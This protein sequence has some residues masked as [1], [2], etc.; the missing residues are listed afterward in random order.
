[1]KLF[2]APVV[3]A[4]LATSAAAFDRQ[5][6]DAL[7]ICH[8]YL[9]EVPDFAALPNAAISVFPGIMD[10]ET[11]TVFWNILWDDPDVRA[12]GNCTVISGELQGFE[13]YTATE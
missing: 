2:L 3:F 1:M 12:A 11:I 8:D 10:G 13:D 4:S 5:T 6:T 9:W 7:Q